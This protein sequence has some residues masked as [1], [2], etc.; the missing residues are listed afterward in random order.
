MENKEEFIDATEENEIPMSDDITFID[1][2]IPLA[3]APVKESKFKIIDVGVKACEIP[4]VGC[5]IK[6]SSSLTFVPE[7]ALQENTDGTFDLIRGRKF[8]G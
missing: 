3:E 1:S 7:A 6:T 4:T 5:I 2:E 8:R